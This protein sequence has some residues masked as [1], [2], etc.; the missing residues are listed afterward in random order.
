MTEEF[1]SRFARS[2]T[3]LALIVFI[4]APTPVSAQDPLLLDVLVRVT[5]FVDEFLEQLSGTVAEERYEQRTRI[6][7]NRGGTILERSLLS[8]FLM[9]KPEGS[10]RHYGFR[11]VFE[12]DGR[13]VRDREE[14]LAKLFLDPSVTSE[15]QIQ[16]ILRESSRYNI[17]DV[18]RTINSPTL[19]LLFLSADYK[20]RFKFE[21]VTDASPSL[22][23]DEFDMAPDVWVI[24]YKE[25]WPT[26]VIRKGSGGNLP[27]EGRF[28]IDRATGR[29]LMSEL[30][31]EGTEWDSVITVRYEADEQ[32]GYFVPVEMRER[33]DHRQ[34][35][36]RIDGTATYTRFRQFQVLVDEAAPFRD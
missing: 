35:I 20:P 8:D 33:Y 36:A 34:S 7:G 31:L 27:S 22:D 29:V 1:T 32:M 3:M 9:I 30:V 15:R 25:A 4:A 17:G 11:D 14:R 6:P 13:P 10:N 18:D 23:V 28:W 26:T 19:A 24:A 16:G 21:R 12:V 5:D 2:F